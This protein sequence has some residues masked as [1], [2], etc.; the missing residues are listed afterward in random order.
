MKIAHVVCTFP[1]YKGGIGNSVYNFAKSLAEIDYDITVF[2]PKY[3]NESSLSEEFL[4]TKFKVKRLKPLIKIGNAAIMPQ[5]FWELK[6]FSIIHFHYPFYGTTSVVLLRKILFWKKTKLIINF[7]MEPT[8]KGFKGLVFKLS[9]II[10]TPILMRS[11]SIITSMTLDY[12]KSSNLYYYYKKNKNKFRETFFGVDLE[13]F[14]PVAKEQDR[15]KSGQKTILFVGGLDKAHYFKG[16]NILLRAI[17]QIKNVDYKLKIVGDGDLREKYEKLSS[18]LR[19]DRKVIFSGRVGDNNLA[20]YYQDCD[21]FVLPS[22]NQG[23]A[24]GMVLLEAMACGKP[25]IAS[26]LPGV[27]SVF[28]NGKQGLLVNPGDVDDLSEKIKVILND[29]SL[30]K[31]MGAEGRKLVEEKYTWEKVGKRLDEVYT[32]VKSL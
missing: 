2:T 8:A 7:I 1:P 24:F 12:V 23:E 16:I 22:I 15:K 3:G 32:K 9:R 20:A 18:D 26:N 25:V 28:K 5:L 29:D 30:A 10:M 17:S 4:N 11:A 13:R 21:V 31:R 14:C 19:L 27:R 6:G